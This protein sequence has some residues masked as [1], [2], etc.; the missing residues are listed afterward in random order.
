MNAVDGRPIEDHVRTECAYEG[1]VGEIGIAK[2]IACDVA[3]FEQDTREV[4]S[5]EIASGIEACDADQR[6]ERS[7]IGLEEMAKRQEAAEV[8]RSL[9]EAIIL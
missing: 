8:I 7:A 3:P 9:I 5:A 6:R 4:R 2:I 1:R